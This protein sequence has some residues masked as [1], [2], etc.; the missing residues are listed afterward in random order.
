MSVDP[1]YY[2]IPE[3]PNAGRLAQPPAPS[4]GFAAL[5]G[6]VEKGANTIIAMNR[7]GAIV[8][9]ARKAAEYDAVFAGKTNALNDSVEA[10]NKGIFEKYGVQLEN[11]WRGGYQAEAYD[12][13][14]A[15][16]GR[17]DP[18][19]PD[20]TGAMR[21]RELALKIWQDKLEETQRQHPDGADVIGAF[22][23]IEDDAK[24]LANNALDQAQKAQ[25][26]AD[27]MVAPFIASFIGGAVGSMRDP[28][29]VV[30]LLATGGTVKAA[31][32]VGKLAENALRQGA[33]N[34]GVA[35]AAEPSVQAWR[36]ERGQKTGFAPAAEDVG[37]AFLVGGAFGALGEGAK[38]GFGALRRTPPGALE[39]AAGGDRAALQAVA[40]ALPAETHAEL[41]A[42]VEADRMDAAAAGPIP[43]GVPDHVAGDVLRQAVR[44]VEDPQAPLP[45]LA[46]AL[47]KG[48]DESAARAA[49][50]GLD[51]PVAAAARLRENP[52]LIE[53]ALSSADP[54]LRRLG[55]VATLSDEAFALVR[56]GAVAPEA[57][58]AVAARVADPLE[59]APM[60]EK[61]R[62]TKAR[63]P[64]DAA[65]FVS[66]ELQAGREH[67]AQS[68]ARGGD[69]DAP[70]RIDAPALRESE[71]QF[72]A[73]VDELS[74]AR[75]RDP[76]P[77][78]SP[79]RR[80]RAPTERAA[81]SLIQFL[82]AKGL[83]FDG[84]I[85]S[86]F[87]NKNPFIPGHGRLFRE[88][89]GRDLD[90]ALRAATDAGYFREAADTQG[91][92]AQLSINDLRQ[93]IFDE[94]HGS[95]RYPEGQSPV[96]VAREKSARIEARR[97]DKARRDAVKAAEK[98]IRKSVKA[99]DQ[100]D[101]PPDIWRRA[102]E[103]HLDDGLDPVSAFDT[104]MIEF[105]R[106]I[107]ARSDQFENV[108]KGR[109][110]DTGGIPGW[111]IPFDERPAP[112]PSGAP[113]G[114][115]GAPAGQ[116]ERTGSAGAEPRPAGERDGPPRGTAGLDDPFNQVAL[117]RADGG[118]DMVARDAL[119]APPREAH[120]ADLIASCK[121]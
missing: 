92:V 96:D 86:I 39:K 108:Q 28:M 58:A 105:E 49:L 63:T 19:A 94:Q 71:T 87:G 2:D 53:S 120:L 89:G 29:N 88:R 95:P 41:K 90:A 57:A 81:P 6:L 75:M 91:G 3:A 116:G 100:S 69:G 21:R 93:A 30:G 119:D 84:D 59:H 115:E 5:D 104:A 46:P 103:K 1:I 14:K 52:A 55:H 109:V 17:F 23:P 64:V 43:A 72:K 20:P 66:E 4:T 114:G 112:R 25:A 85:H 54:Q 48:V 37:M 11:P 18:D 47:A 56:E 97:E 44:H 22:R 99:G 118:V 110:H 78:P 106:D 13:W 79:P 26:A 34:A 77:E 80:Q 70:A 101:F 42:H 51:E 67:V 50:A 31:S 76:P 9:T 24:T 117:E 10:R 62:K 36:A 121:L 102:A 12:R 60:L 45:E 98:N 74:G 113:A 7:L 15:D 35:A 83:K 27:G 73:Q 16:P 32:V 38:A 111:D 65:D 8:S 82:A 33:V 68:L 107:L 40:D 61:L